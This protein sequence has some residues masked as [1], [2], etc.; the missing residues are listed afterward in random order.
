MNYFKV[1]FFQKRHTLYVLFR[2]LVLSIMPCFNTVAKKNINPLFVT[3]IFTH[4]GKL[5]KYLILNS[6]KIK[7]KHFFLVH[8]HCLKTINQYNQKSFP[9]SNVTWSY[10]LLFLINVWNLLLY[11][12]KQKNRRIK[13]DLFVKVNTTVCVIFNDVLFILKA[14]LRQKLRS[15][16]TIQTNAN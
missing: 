12:K 15:K 8:R 1:T 16:E 7:K 11:K 5:I 4:E 13:S 6:V 3:K 10:N 14:Y 9:W 2:L